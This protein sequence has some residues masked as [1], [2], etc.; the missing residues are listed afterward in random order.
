MGADLLLSPV[1]RLSTWRHIVEYFAKYHLRRPVANEELVQKLMPSYPIG[2]KRII[3]DSQFYLTLK[4][5]K[6]DIVTKPIT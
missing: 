5:K 2:S 4:L 3:F 6:V 1:T